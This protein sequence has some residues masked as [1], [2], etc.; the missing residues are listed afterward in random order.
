MANKS[1]TNKRP[2]KKT[3]KR[4]PDRRTLSDLRKR[5][6]DG[7]ARTPH[8]PTVASPPSVPAASPHKLYRTYRLAE[9]FDVDRTTIY[10]WRKKGK[11]PFARV[12]DFWAVTEANL[13]RVLRP[14]N[15]DGEDR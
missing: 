6:L 4:A 8:Q 13:Q 12:G 2:S 14:A 1:P 9:L 10:R 11:L 15:G 7:V 5:L 3:G